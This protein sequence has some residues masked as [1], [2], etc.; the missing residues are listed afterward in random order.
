MGLFCCQIGCEVME[1]V[2]GEGM[3]GGPI[4]CRVVGMVHHWMMEFGLVGV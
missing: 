2:H 1:F 3:L 4:G